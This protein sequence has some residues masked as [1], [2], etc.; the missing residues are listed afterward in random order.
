MKLKSVVISLTAGAAAGAAAVLL[1]PK[2]SETYQT[3]NEA[4]QTV[5]ME[6]SR[7]WDSLKQS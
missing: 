1:M 6:A 3:M 7:M 5:K 4:A 2:N